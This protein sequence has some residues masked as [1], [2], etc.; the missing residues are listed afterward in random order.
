MQLRSMDKEKE[1]NRGDTMT[2][3]TGERLE[4]TE[5]STSKPT[6]EIDDKIDDLYRAVR[7]SNR[8][9]RMFWYIPDLKNTQLKN[10][11][12]GRLPHPNKPLQILIKAPE[13]R[14]FFKTST[15]EICIDNGR[16]YMYTD[17]K[18]DIGVGLADEPF[19][20]DKLEE[21]FSELTMVSE[22]THQMER[23]PLME[24]TTPTTEVMALGKFKNNISKFFK[25]CKM[26]G[27]TSC[28][29]AR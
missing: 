15:F 28:E 20:L 3:H 17:P 7:V 14:R 21:H 8:G 24:R 5:S 19:E 6:H 26:Y 12:D 25:L 9:V 27:E 29:L 18:V 10:I 2:H 1:N 11:A 22:F 23:I 13:L 16:M 4:V